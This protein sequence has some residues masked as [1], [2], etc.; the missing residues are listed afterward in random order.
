MIVLP[1]RDSENS[2]GID[3]LDDLAEGKA[4]V[5]RARPL[6]EVIRARY[7]TYAHVCL[8]S[9]AGEDKWPRV[10][11]PALPEIRD[12]EGVVEVELTALDYDNVRHEPLDVEGYR[13]LLKRLEES[14]VSY[15]PTYIW[16]TRSGARF[17]FVHAPLTPERAESFHVWLREHYEA[18]GIPC[19][20]KVW[21]WNRPHALPWVVRDGSALDP[22]Q[23]LE[24]DPIKTLPDFPDKPVALRINT[25]TLRADQPDPI[26]A[27]SLVW[28]D[29]DASGKLTEWGAWAKLRMRGRDAEAA[30][31]VPTIPEKTRNPTLFKW[32][33]SIVSMCYGLNDTSPTHVMG[34]LAPSVEANL[35]PGLYEE[36]WRAVCYCWAREEAQAAQTEIARRGFLETFK[37]EVTTWAKDAPEGE[38]EF[39]EW[40]K[41]RLVVSF[42]SDYYVLRANGRYGVQP[43]K[44]SALVSALRTSGLVGPGRVV[45]RLSKVNAKGKEEPIRCQDVIDQWSTPLDDVVLQG[46]AVVGGVLEEERSMAMTTYARRTDIAPE[47]S[48]WTEGWFSAWFGEHKPLV[49]EWLSCAYDFEGGPQAALSLDCAGGSG[50]NLLMRAL[51]FGITSGSYSTGKQVLGQFQPKLGK[52]PFVHVDETWPF[53]KGVHAAFRELIGTWTQSVNRKNIHEAEIR[54]CPRVLMTANKANLVEVLFGDPDMTPTEHEAT[55]E[56]IIH[57]RL[58][59][60]G[61]NWITEHGG[62]N[63]ASEK[64]ESFEISR[65]LLWLYQNV[66]RSRHGRFLM[67]GDPNDPYLLSLGFRSVAVLGEVLVR[68]FEIGKITPI[69]KCRAQEVLEHMDNME[70]TDRVRGYNLITLGKHLRNFLNPDRTLNLSKLADFATT[71]GMKCPKLRGALKR[72]GV[73]RDLV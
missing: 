57:L 14:G 22:D 9:F 64:L 1:E 65:H 45:P 73:K 34:V 51:G 69:S 21:E 37:D 16:K 26:D 15:R 20:A 52:S 25:R 42:G 5:F 61:K 27:A 30:W 6:D 48:E 70:L 46:G 29:S 17:L 47:R 32:A 53:Q 58:G 28:K 36:T 44:H 68:M 59:R 13:D 50:K 43:V 63:T 56:R 2:R 7:S 31:E 71:A 67:V 33:G 41:P 3:S 19:D 8:Y 18:H 40:V 24:F 49:E 38:E 10:N 23:V 4:R 60:S 55:A 35:R 12:E 72:Q 62:M 66:S 39:T 11:K 54:T